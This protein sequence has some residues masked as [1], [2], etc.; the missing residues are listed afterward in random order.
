MRGCQRARRPRRHRARVRRAGRVR[1]AESPRHSRP[2][3]K[4]G[5]PL[6][7]ALLHVRHADGLERLRRVRLV[8]L[9][10]RARRRAR[11][12]HST[13]SAA[14]SASDA[15]RLGVALVEPSAAAPR[16]GSASARPA[17]RSCGRARPA[18]GVERAHAVLADDLLG[19]DVPNRLRNWYTGELGCVTAP[20]LTI[21][22]AA[23]WPLCTPA[24]AD[25][26]RVPPRRARRRLDADAAK[27]H[28]RAPRRRGRA[29]RRARSRRPWRPSRAPRPP[30]PATRVERAVARPATTRSARREIPRLRRPSCR[31]RQSRRREARPRRR[32]PG[33]ATSDAAPPSPARPS[34]PG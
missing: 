32:A 6:G 33:P 14:T 15:P 4:A 19:H 5:A 30:R 3:T 9:E 24:R 17:A 16:A 34:S 13:Q 18:R 11:A 2:L 7:S 25:E 20:E 28:A 26:A 31:A 1:S 29:E 8:A 22:A 27:T 23:R 21:R 12:G 10:G